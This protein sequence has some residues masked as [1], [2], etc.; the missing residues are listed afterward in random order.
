MLR[1]NNPATGT[2]SHLLTIFITTL[3]CAVFSAG[4]QDTCDELLPDDLGT[5]SLCENGSV[6]LSLEETYDNYFWQ[7][8]ATTPSITVSQSGS[9]CVTVTLDTCTDESCFLVVLEDSPEP[10]IQGDPLECGFTAVL[11]AGPG[12]TSYS[13]TTGETTQIITVADPDEF[14][15]TV[16][17][18]SGCTGIA[19]YTVVETDLQVSISGQNYFCDTPFDTI[20]LD[21]GADFD[22]YTWNTGSSNQSIEVFEAGIYS[23]TVENASGCSGMDTLIVTEAFVPE[24]LLPELSACGFLD[25]SEF[26]LPNFHLSWTYDSLEVDT[27]FETGIYTLTYTDMIFGCSGSASTLIEIGEPPVYDLLGD[28]VFCANHTVTLQVVPDTFSSYLWSTSETGSFFE[29]SLP[30]TYCVSVFDDTGCMAS[31]C[32]SLDTLP[33][34]RATNILITPD[35]GSGSGSVSF[36]VFNGT[37]PYSYAW[38]PGNSGMNLTAGIYLVVI[39]DANG[40]SSAFSFEIPLASSTQ[41]NVNLNGLAIFPNPTSNTWKIS[42]ENRQDLSK[43]SLELYDSSGRLVEKCSSDEPEIELGA[44][45]SNGVYLLIVED[46]EGHRSK[47]TLIKI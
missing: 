47:R 42:R 38:D 5:V 46:A 32:I 33:F 23:V 15:V 26:S 40:C 2:K 36:D 34:P 31:K 29:V 25:L 39:S 14:C 37:P 35:D 1:E 6:L 22:S 8:S 43:L 21:A 17:N 28:T 9:Y 3:F 30:G 18:A 27:A 7:T 44:S 45:L 24:I 16:T 12:Y 4:A 11:D 13:W 19:C 20:I 10:E 41:E